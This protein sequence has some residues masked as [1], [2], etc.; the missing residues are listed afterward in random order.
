VSVPAL[1]PG[2]MLGGYR[3]EAPLGAGAVGVVYRATAPDGTP[4]A[5]KVLRPE[6]SADERFIARFSREARAAAGLEGGH[7]ATVLDA[8][9][10]GGRHF[11]V[12]RYVPGGTLRDRLNAD[13]PLPVP[14][15]V[16]MAAHV[17]SALDAVHGAGLLHRD[18]KPA[19]VLLDETGAAYLADF[20]LAKGDAYTVLTKPGETMGTLDYLAPELVRGEPAT[21]ASDIYAFGCVVYEAAT[22][23][24]PFAGRGLLQVGLAHLHEPPPDPAAVRPELGEGSAWAVVQA[25]AKDPAQRPATATAYAHMLSVAARIR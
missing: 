5:L 23:A 14:D 10:D 15:L 8:G 2:T 16:R 21:T 1:A 9:A 25:L 24:T 3:I 11:L 22:G 19:N 18:L 7:V 12:T 13:G 20:G 17:G 4:V 6:L